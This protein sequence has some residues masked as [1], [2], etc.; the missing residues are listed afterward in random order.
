MGSGGRR[1][2]LAGHLVEML[3]SAGG[4]GVEL[5]ARSLPLLPGV[6]AQM[7]MGMIPGGAYRNREA[8]GDRVRIPESMRRPWEMLLYDPQTSGGLLAAIAP[9]AG[10]GF[11]AEAARRGVRARRMGVFNDTALIELLA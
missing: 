3:G 2:P 1:R 7:Q 4:L 11:E 6:H 10:E 5:R 8:Y 9:E